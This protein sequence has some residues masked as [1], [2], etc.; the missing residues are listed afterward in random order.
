MLFRVGGHLHW[1]IGVPATW[2]DELRQV[3]DLDAAQALL[4][5]PVR[6]G[7][8]PAAVPGLSGRAPGITP[9]SRRCASICIEKSSLS[10]CWSVR[11]AGHRSDLVGVLYYAFSVF[12]TPIGD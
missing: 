1:P 4:A 10:G 9:P 12:L 5:Y 11:L 2:E 3:I 8:R 6:S 7:R